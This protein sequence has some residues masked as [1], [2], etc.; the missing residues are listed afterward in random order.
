MVR[1]SDAGV[2]PDLIQA[3][4]AL[5]PNNFRLMATGK[6]PKL[7][8]SMSILQNGKGSEIRFAT[9]KGRTAP[10][11]SLTDSNIIL[12]FVSQ[13]D[14]WKDFPNRSLSASCAASESEVMEDFTDRNTFIVVPA[15]RITKF[16][17]TPTDFNF[18]NI[19]KHQLMSI[20]SR[21][22]YTLN[23]LRDLANTD[24]PS[25][26]SKIFR[27]PVVKKINKADIMSLD[28]IYE[29]SV[30][31]HTFH[32]HDSSQ[33]D[34]I[35]WFENNKKLRLTHTYNKAV[36]DV[37]DLYTYMG[38]QTLWDFLHTDVS[39]SSMKAKLLTINQL[40]TVA[41]KPK[42]EIW[43]EGDYLIIRPLD[44]DYDGVLTKILKAMK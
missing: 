41:K 33:Q 16:A 13:S 9:V 24:L 1:E 37:D 38:G 4:N 28:D 29:L 10:R 26:L 5:C 18:T 44:D 12:N 8:R 42:S 36:V 25:T 34:I 30:I 32:E 2:D 19:R 31:M 23:M 6:I 35:D 21:L 39:P 43:F 3:I 7:Y 20:G 14:L 27:N 40:K 11:K 22:K 15:D 17:T